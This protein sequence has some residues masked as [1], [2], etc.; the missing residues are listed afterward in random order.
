MSNYAKL[1]ESRF[2]SNINAEFKMAQTVMRLDIPFDVDE[3]GLRF[4]PEYTK[5]LYEFYLYDMNCIQ[6]LQLA[7]DDPNIVNYVQC[8]Y[9]IL[10]FSRKKKLVDESLMYTHYIN[11]DIPFYRGKHKIDNKFVY[12]AM[13]DTRFI[14]PPCSTN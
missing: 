14:I 12:T 9:L 6:D 3:I 1:V 2:F 4:D 10:F 13:I 11:G 8:E 5:S 7:L